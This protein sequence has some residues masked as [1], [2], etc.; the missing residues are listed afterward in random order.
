MPIE[1]EIDNL[2]VNNAAIEYISEKPTDTIKVNTVCQYQRK[3]IA[4]A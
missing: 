4:N 2:A 3:K 1:L